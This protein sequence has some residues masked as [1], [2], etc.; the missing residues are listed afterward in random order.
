MR[1][2]LIYTSVKKCLLFQITANGTTLTLASSFLKTV[3]HSYVYKKN[4]SVMDVTFIVMDVT[5]CVMDMTLRVMDVTTSL[6]N[7]MQS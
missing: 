2:S 1:S 7:N 3:T 4:N 5:Q 6:Q